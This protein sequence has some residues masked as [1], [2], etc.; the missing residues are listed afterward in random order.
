MKIL[1]CGML[2]LGIFDFIYNDWWRLK[3]CKK[4]IN[5]Y[6]NNSGGQVYYIKRISRTENLYKIKY[7]LDQIDNEAT[8][9]FNFSYTLKIL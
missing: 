5:E 2:I 7:T 6:I 1:L 9:K 3:K 8:V 4:K